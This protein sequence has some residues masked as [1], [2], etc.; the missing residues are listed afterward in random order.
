MDYLIHFANSSFLYVLLPLILIAAGIK[1][2]FPRSLVYRY[3]LAGVL[4]MNQWASRHPFRTI[5][6]FLRMS[7]LILMAFLIAKPQLIDSRSKVHV[8]GIDIVL[9]LDVS[10]SML[11]IDDVNDKRTRLEV[12]KAE[13]VRFIERRENDAIGVVVFGNEAVSRC[14]L[15]MDKNM[16]RSMV[17][18]L[19]IGIIDPSRTK[20]ATA[21]IMAANRLKKSQAK[22]KIIILLTDG[23]PSPEDTNPE[24]ALEV[25]K[26]MGIKIYTVGIGGDKEGYIR[27]PLYGM[28]PVT[29]H[30]NKELLQK[31]ASETGGQFFEAKKSGDMR[32]IYDTIDSLERTT[33]ETN[34]Y[35]NVYDYFMPLL[36]AVVILLMLEVILSSLVWFSL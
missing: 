2:K 8:E 13:A 3:P 24:I 28:I 35:Q 18:E 26:R 29:S 9:D 12:A 15:T 22:S 31:I 17:K 10:E 6:Y 33:I 23:E 36:W 16:L 21:I 20:L 34:A 14:P 32:Q 5:F 11:I 19:E 30:L 27:H 1:W 7:A 4:K 25:A